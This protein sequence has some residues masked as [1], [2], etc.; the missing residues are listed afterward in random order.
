MA[1]VSFRKKPA[2]LTPGSI[3]AL[4]AAGKTHERKSDPERLTQQNKVREG[5]R[6]D[7]KRGVQGADRYIPEAW[8]DGKGQ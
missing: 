6:D 8:P 7:D 3:P 5:R 4:L 1:L 2:G